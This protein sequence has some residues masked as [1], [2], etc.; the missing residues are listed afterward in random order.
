MFESLCS[1]FLFLDSMTVLQREPLF[2]S[3]FLFCHCNSVCS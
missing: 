1:V 2:C 3:H